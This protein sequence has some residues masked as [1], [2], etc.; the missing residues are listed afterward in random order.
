MKT[1]G[2]FILKGKSQS[3]LEEFFLGI[4]QPRYRARQAF[5]RIN[6]HLSA[7]LDDFSEFPISLRQSLAEI[8][9]F[10][11]LQWLQSQREAS[12]VEKALFALPDDRAGRA[13][14]FE[15]VW[16]VSENRRTICISSQLGCTLNCS[17]CATGTLEFR[18]NLETWQIVDQVYE[19][20][21]RRKETI[22]NVVFMGMGEPFHNYENVLR[23]ARILHHPDGMNLGA[24]HI[25]ISTAGVIPGIE[26]FIQNR[27]PFNLAISLN[28]PDPEQRGEIMDIDRKYPLRELL[29]VARRFTREL[30]RRLTFEYV[31]IPGV[32]MGPSELRQL[33]KI[34]RSVRCKV[35]LI[36]LNTDLHGW[37]RPTE[38][39]SSSF[40]S[41]LLDAGVMAFNRGSP[42]RSINGACGMLALKSAS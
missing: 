22:S 32:N 17:F 41:A 12:G 2:D 20:I 19:L 10:P 15:A 5:Q 38:E 25:T 26:R 28:H 27:E 40:Y 6:K 29:I 8:G 31:M 1:G 18:G 7:S 33:I 9:A 11:E 42:G 16:L 13:R 30:D 34:A 36:P 3:E 24:R 4:E 35:N 37:R 14:R 21:R 39:E 23:A